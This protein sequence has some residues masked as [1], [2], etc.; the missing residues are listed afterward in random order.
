MERLKC[1]ICG[2]KIHLSIDVSQNHPLAKGA[3][4][5]NEYGFHIG[6]IHYKFMNVLEEAAQPKEQD[7]ILN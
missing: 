2:K 5:H 4:C 3:V 7:L 1:P 6:L